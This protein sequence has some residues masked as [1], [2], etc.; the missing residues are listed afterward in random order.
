M[1]C[2]GRT[3]S[4]NFRKRCSKQAGLLFCWQHT[5]QPLIAFTCLVTL[6]AGIAELSGFNIRDL[7]NR[8]IEASPDSDPQG[9]LLRDWYCG[10]MK[11]F[12]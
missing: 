11:D 5:W 7:I 4:S 9:W 6:G 1:K 12:S 8:M 10:E 3:R 2:F